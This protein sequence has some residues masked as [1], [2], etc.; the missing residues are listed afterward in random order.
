MIRDMNV[1]QTTHSPHERCS[2]DSAGRQTAAAPTQ[3][4]ARV[5]IKSKHWRGDLVHWRRLG[6]GC[7]H[8]IAPLLLSLPRPGNHSYGS[9]KEEGKCRDLALI[10]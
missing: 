5:I 10:Q 8:N 7:N 1:D 2:G 3:V 9:R 4:P 6:A